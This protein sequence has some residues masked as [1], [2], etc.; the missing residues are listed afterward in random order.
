MSPLHLM[1]PSF[2]PLLGVESR[3]FLYCFLSLSLRQSVIQVCKDLFVIH[4]LFS[5]TVFSSWP[6][7]SYSSK[8]YF[9]TSRASSNL[10][11]HRFI[12]LCSNTWSYHLHCRCLSLAFKNLHNR[13]LMR[14]RGKLVQWEGLGL[15]IQIN[16]GSNLIF[17]LSVV[18]L[19]RLTLLIW[20]MGLIKPI[21]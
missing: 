1:L 4:L 17:T 15:Q 6:F 18:R 2:S 19:L 14:P 20:K 21:S 8:L 11:T 10:S 9:S 5:F 16:M 13:I 7:H 12:F 3:W